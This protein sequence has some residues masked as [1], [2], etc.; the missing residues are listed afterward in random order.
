MHM[1]AE[2][3]SVYAQTVI[4]TNK[5]TEQQLATAQI[6][7]E[8]LSMECKRLRILLSGQIKELKSMK[9][10]VCKPLERRIGALEVSLEHAAVERD[11][12]RRVL[13]ASYREITRADDDDGDDDAACAEAAGAGAGASG[14][15]GGRLRRTGSGRGEK[16]I[17]TLMCGLP[18]L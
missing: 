5:I 12:F 17:T 9:N 3:F 6:E 8:Q 11:T 7:N 16:Y 1:A 10:A 2:D 14:G 4:I 15:G 13:Q 18:Y